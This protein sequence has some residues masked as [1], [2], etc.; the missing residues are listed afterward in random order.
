MFLSVGASTEAKALHVCSVG[1][2]STRHAVVCVFLA[3]IK[4]TISPLTLAYYPYP[5]L[6]YST[7]TALYPT[8]HP[9]STLLYSTASYCTRLDSAPT[10]PHPTLPLPHATLLAHLPYSN[11]TAIYSTPHP[12][13]TLLY[14]LPL[15]HSTLYSAPTPLYPTLPLQHSS[16][17][18][19]PQLHPTLLH[20]YSTLPLL[21][22]A[23]HLRRRAPQLRT[24][25][26]HYDTSDCCPV[27]ALLHC[28]TAALS[29]CT[30]CPSCPPARYRPAGQ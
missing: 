14:T 18:T 3:F 24:L 20:P 5:A 2:V 9:Y 22:L 10:P 15:L 26:T 6:L 19:Q 30:L 21:H 23:R 12:Y 25:H 27:L 4:I 17:L 11:A 28:Y 8:P 16:L 7:T 29:L 1:S 13:S